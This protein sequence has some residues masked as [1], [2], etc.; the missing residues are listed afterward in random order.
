M[1]RSNLHDVQGNAAHGARLEGMEVRHGEKIEGRCSGLKQCVVEG[2]QRA[3]ERL[4]SLEMAHTEAE[5][6]RAMLEKQFDDLCLE[7]HHV[8]HFM[9]RETMQHAHGGQGIFD[10]SDPT[11]VVTP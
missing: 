10:G 4:I 5:A 7:V 2:E 1:S 9:E 8:N 11:L 6:S 3:E